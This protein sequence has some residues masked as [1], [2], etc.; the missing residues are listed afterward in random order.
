VI[1][2]IDPFLSTEI[3]KGSRWGSEIDTALEGTQFGIVCLTR[4]N[5]SAPWVLFEAG[6][7]SKTTGALIWTFLMDVAPT[8]VP[9]PLAKF[10]HTNAE[11]NDILRLL[12]TINHRVDLAGE[13]ALQEQA[14]DDIFD[15]FWPQLANHLQSAKSAREVDIGR[16]RSD[17]E[18]I[19][20]VLEILRQDGRQL[21]QTT[22]YRTRG[23]LAA[24]V[25]RVIRKR[26]LF[27]ELEVEWKL[28]WDPQDISLHAIRKS[29]ESTF[30]VSVPVRSNWPQGS[31]WS[32]AVEVADELKRLLVAAL[33]E[34]TPI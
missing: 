26:D 30:V 8:D 15:L 12:H 18:L 33:E 28:A 11:K 1:Q 9:F 22:S 13:R 4:E 23:Y 2:A 29:D 10:Q 34:H 14:L 21:P 19:E 5:L 6:A 7:L 16:T 25:E 31:S 32:Y 3:E 24:W 20:E 27:A 17:R